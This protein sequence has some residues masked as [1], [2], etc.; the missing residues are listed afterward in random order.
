[1][2]LNLKQKK[3]YYG[4]NNIDI[5]CVDV[6][7]YVLSSAIVL[8]SILRKTQGRRQPQPSGVA[9]GA[10]FWS[11]GSGQA[12]PERP[13]AGGGFLGRRQPVPC[14]PSVGSKERC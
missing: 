5:T 2:K 11:G 6:N 13:R 4:G 9:L 12:R 1:L 10:Q 3:H 14:P 7:Y 8:L